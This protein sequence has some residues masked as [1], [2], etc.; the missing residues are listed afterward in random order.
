MDAHE[1]EPT[2]TTL[3]I[4]A[5]QR[6]AVEAEQRRTDLT[7]RVRE[8]LDMVKAAALGDDLARIARWSGR[9]GETVAHWL[10]RFAAGG[11]AALHTARCPPLRPAGA[12]RYTLSGGP[13][14]RPGDRADCFGVGLRC[15]D[16]PAP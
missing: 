9:S 6:R 12:G 14:D 13:G 1:T 7:R 15:L 16:L 4:T 11:I 3:V 10:A 2:T 8:R 5:E